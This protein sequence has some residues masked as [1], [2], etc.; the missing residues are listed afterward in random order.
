MGAFLKTICVATFVFT[1]L[2]TWSQTEYRSNQA[3]I[4]Q[5]RIKQMQVEWE[6]M[7][8]QA[9]TERLQKEMHKPE[10]VWD[11]LARQAAEQKAAEEKA[12]QLARQQEEIQQASIRSANNLYAIFFVTTLLAIG[13]QVRKKMT[14]KPVLS[15]HQKFG[16][17]VMIFTVIALFFV[18]MISDDWTTQLDL[19]LNFLRIRIRFWAEQEYSSYPTYLID[20]PTKYALMAL[21][22]G[23]TYGFTTYLGI[24]PAWERARAFMAQEENL[25][26]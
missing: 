19:V 9:E 25:E 16:I 7:R 18:L 17:L 13:Y 3:E 11:V 21:L 20:F 4:D 12:E 8:L 5:L 24:T 15:F 6:T 2:A 14:T 26:K 22:V 23:F 1:S 10:N